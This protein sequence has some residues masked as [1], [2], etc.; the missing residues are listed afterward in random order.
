ME[1]ILVLLLTTN[2][3]ALRIID[4]IKKK[5]NLIQSKTSCLCFILIQNRGGKHMGQ[6]NSNLK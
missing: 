6:P 2:K 3:T 4:Y 1:Y 5:T